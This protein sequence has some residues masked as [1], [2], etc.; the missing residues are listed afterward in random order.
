MKT[1]YLVLISL[2]VIFAV[3]ILCMVF[4]D[5][6]EVDKNKEEEQI[7][8]VVDSDVQYIDDENTTIENEDAL[9]FEVS[10]EYTDIDFV[11]SLKSK[12]YDKNTNLFNFK[13]N[14]RN[15]NNDNR[16][17]DYNK[18]SC[19]VNGQAVPVTVSENITVTAK[20]NKD[21]EIKCAATSKDDEVYINYTSV[22]Y[23]GHQVPV[24][25]GK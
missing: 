19:V 16:V 6:E 3:V 9:N 15:I 8:E 4:G 18:I 22:L 2:V 23:N 25:F 5:S 11:I 12:K 17:I 1:R 24:K 13:L 21:I 14:F 7:Q 20:E 10:Q